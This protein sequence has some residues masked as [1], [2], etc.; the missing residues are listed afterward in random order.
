MKLKVIG[1]LLPLGLE[2]PERLELE[3]GLVI[4]KITPAEKEAKRGNS[5]LTIRQW[6]FDSLQYC[7][8]ADMGEFTEKP[9]VMSESEPH[10]YKEAEERLD[11]VIFILRLF[12]AGTVGYHEFDIFKDDLYGGTISRTTYFRGR[13]F[14]LPES[15]IDSLVELYEKIKSLQ[16]ISFTNIALERFRRIYEKEHPED[17]LIDLFVALESLFEADTEISYRLSLCVSC[18]LYTEMIERKKCFEKI[19]K[20]Y[21]M[22]SKIV[23]GSLSDKDLAKLP[24]TTSHIEDVV[25]AIILKVLISKQGASKKTFLDY[26]EDRILS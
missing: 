9:W 11:K 3:K 23:H 25:R 16:P 24:D 21:G 12:K 20:A 18:Y 15:E 26:V 17:R 22:R 1:Y 8:E 2:F 5:I 19:R 10:P 13:A 4:R 6:D 14:K 7:I